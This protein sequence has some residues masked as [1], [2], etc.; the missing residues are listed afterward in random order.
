MQISDDVSDQPPKVEIKTISPQCNI[1]RAVIITDLQDAV[2]L[3]ENINTSDDAVAKAVNDA[4][5]GVQTAGE[6]IKNILTALISGRTQV[7]KGLGII[8]TALSG[9]NSTET[10]IEKIE[11]NIAA[12]N[13]R[14]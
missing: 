2:F 4:K 12:G 1:A 3:L 7:D 5:H 8:R 13:E 9:L 14:I 6:G 10:D 11:D